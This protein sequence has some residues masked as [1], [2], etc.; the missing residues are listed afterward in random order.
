MTEKSFRP[1]EPVEVSLNFRAMNTQI[2]LLIYPPAQEAERAVALGQ[3]VETMFQETEA[4]LSR[5]RS[6]SELSKLNN[7]GYLDNVS[8]LLYASVAAACRMRDLTEGV[9]DPTILKALEAAGYDRSFELLGQGT[10]QVFTRHV[11]VYPPQWQGAQQP[12]IE[13]DPTRRSIRLAPGIKIDLGGIAKGMTVDR[14][15]RLLREA[16]FSSFM[17]SAGGDMYLEGQPP[18]DNRGWL[19]EVANEA[20]GHS[21]NIATLQVFNK[22]VA[23]SSTTG[24]RWQLGGQTRH[25]LIDPRT[26]QPAATDLAGVTVVAETVEM[27]DVMAKTALILGPEQTTRLNLKQTANLSTILFVTLQGELIE[28]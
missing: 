12:K 1:E 14:A 2:E 20:P 5:F 13:L 26:G 16:G 10:P 9:F 28:V 7:Q 8:E 3:Q 24:R 6:D 22:A 15:A 23:T 11:T 18:Q 17:I 4:A 25:H 27:A 21:G 19:V